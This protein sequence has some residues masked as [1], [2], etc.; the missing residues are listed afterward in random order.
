MLSDAA[1]ASR[2][3]QIFHLFMLSSLLP[4]C[5]IP[6]QSFPS[7][8]ASHVPHS[9]S[10]RQQRGAGRIDCTTPEHPLHHVAITALSLVVFPHS[11]PATPEEASGLTFGD[12]RFECKVVALARQPQ[13]PDF[14]FDCAAHAQQTQ[15][16]DGSQVSTS[17]IR[18][19]KDHHEEK[20]C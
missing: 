12:G 1:I 6:P 15:E 14:S 16:E 4:L 19:Q 10:N 20:S 8:H 17:L 3:V 18:P 5:L 7:Q 2:T 11:P 13:Y 9:T